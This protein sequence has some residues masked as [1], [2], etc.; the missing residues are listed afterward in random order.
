[1]QSITIRIPSALRAFA[2]G[3]S[4]CQVQAASVREA[5]SA[6][7]TEHTLLA[8]KILSRG[9]ELRPFVN[10]FLDDDDVRLLNGLDTPLRGE[11]TITIVPSV[12]GG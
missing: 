5:L 1:M 7:Q 4:E 8:Q 2:G 11:R 6:L 3:A 10:L 9:G 12:A